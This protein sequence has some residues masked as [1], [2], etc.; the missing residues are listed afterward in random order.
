MIEKIVKQWTCEHCKKKYY[1]K[2][3]A[4]KHEKF[5]LKNP[6]NDHKCFQHCTHLIKGSEQYTTVDIGHYGAYGEVNR[7]T[8][9]CALT[10]KFM[11]S[12]IAERK[13]IVPIYNDYDAVGRTY[14]RMPLE[15]D[16]YKDQMEIDLENL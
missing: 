8:F 7:A 14:E 11:Y 1:V 9:Q 10:G 12:A 5:C 13:N 16:L 15:C 6:A 4:E 3:A 2:H